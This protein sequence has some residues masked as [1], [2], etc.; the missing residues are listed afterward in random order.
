LDRS[1]DLAVKKLIIETMEVFDQEAAEGYRIAA[2]SMRQETAT[3]DATRR[4]E[5]RTSL[6]EDLLDCIDKLAVPEDA[7]T[8]RAWQSLCN[9]VTTGKKLLQ[10]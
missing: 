6:I 3:E 8:N 5:A 1:H 7:A 10:D 4:L 2:E 9:L